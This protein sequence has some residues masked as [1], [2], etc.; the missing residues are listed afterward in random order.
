MHAMQLSGIDANL[1]VVL[2]ALLETRNVTRAGQQLGLSPSATSHALGRLREA[3]GDPLLVRAGRALVPTPRAL[4]LKDDVARALEMLDGTLKV[5]TPLEPERLSRSFHVE[6]TDHV[7]FVLLH[8]LDALVR[9][10][11]PHVNVYLQSLQPDTFGRLRQGGI[12]LAISVYST[13][14][15]DLEKQVLFEDHLVAVVR[16]GHPVLRRRLTLER[17]AR[18]THLLVAPNG[19]PT[20]LVDRL[21]A[22]HG[23]K[24]RIART[25]STFLDMA[26]LVAETDY[27]VSLPRSLAL[28][29]LPRLG[30]KM[31]P[32]PLRL[33]SFTHSM[34]WHRRYTADPAHG[35]FRAL[36][37]RTCVSRGSR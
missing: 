5:A 30:L 12:D 33:P 1:F 4:G 16:R 3:L 10:E 20:G 31:L 15:P 17:F 19:T 27:V 13:V 21:L 6:T 24:R 2:N 32:L 26:F 23:L 22:E 14:D 9:A 25:S 35:W 11:G 8:R 29:L 28:P 18:C 36:V 37:A 7:Q 34:I